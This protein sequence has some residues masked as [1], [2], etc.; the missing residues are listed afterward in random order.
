MLTPFFWRNDLAEGRLTRPFGQ[1]SSRGYAYWL[2]CPEHRRQ[3]PKIKRFR[4]WLTS[5]VQRHVE[6]QGA[7]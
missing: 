7:G 6:E 4:E 3:V 2:V 5:E 1:V